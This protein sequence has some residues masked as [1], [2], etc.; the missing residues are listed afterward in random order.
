MRKYY[1]AWCVY[2][3]T[4]GKQKVYTSIL[5]QKTVYWTK[6]RAFLT[7]LYNNG[8]K[9]SVEKAVEAGNQREIL[10]ETVHTMRQVDDVKTEKD[11]E[12]ASL[13]ERLHERAKKTLCG[14]LARK[15][16]ALM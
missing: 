16:R 1:N 7:W 6:K 15:N 10:D 5:M 13:K 8:L 14:H 4:Y 3:H 9:K 11:H 2:R 12:L